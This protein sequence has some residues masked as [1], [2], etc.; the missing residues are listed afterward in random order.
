MSRSSIIIVLVVLVVLSAGREASARSTT[1]SP[2][3]DGLRTILRDPN[4]KMAYTPDRTAL[5]L[6]SRRAEISLGADCRMRLHPPGTVKR[7]L[8]ISKGARVDL[9]RALGHR[10]RTNPAAMACLARLGRQR[11]VTWQLRPD[12]LGFGAET[13]TP[14][15]RPLDIWSSAA[16]LTV[17]PD[18]A[19]TFKKLQRSPFGFDN[20]EPSTGHGG[21]VIRLLPRAPVRQPRPP[22]PRQAPTC[23]TP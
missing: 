9:G 15:T 16:R 21:G 14:R 22:R 7:M 6:L 20:H 19:C 1:S 11:D 18:G 12:G 13:Y 8:M 4:K 2:L 23:Y 5:I 17:A 3:L 10:K